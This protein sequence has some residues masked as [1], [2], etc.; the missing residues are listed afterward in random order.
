MS[1]VIEV[2]RSKM[3]L[4]ANCTLVSVSA[5]LFTNERD[6]LDFILSCL[7]FCFLVVFGD[8]RF[9]LQLDYKLSLQFNQ[10]HWRIC[11]RK[12]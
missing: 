3:R 7:L 5:R 11:V 6:L 10:I 12:R 8:S 4:I 9:Y 1:S 2:C